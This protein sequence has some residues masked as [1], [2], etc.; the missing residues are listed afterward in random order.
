MIFWIITLLSLAAATSGAI[1]WN[2]WLFP[3]YLLGS[4]VILAV[5]AIAFVVIA[6]SCIDRSKPQ[7]GDS[8][9]YRGLANHYIRF[10]KTLARLQIRTQGLEKL[11]KDGRF[12]LVCNHLHELDPAMLLYCFPKSQLAFIAKQ[13]I[14]GFFLVGPLL[15]K[16]QC[17]LIN[18]ENDREALKTIL[19]CIQIVKEDK[20][21]MGVFPEGYCSVSGKLYHFRS[22]VFKIAQKTGV[23]VVVCTIRGTKEV[24]PR[25]LKLR[26]AAVDVH[27]VDVISAEQVKALSTVDLAELAYET[28]IA[29]LGEALRTDEKAVHPDLQKQQL[30][31][32]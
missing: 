17:Q 3:L 28:M 11:P 4:F 23:P 5:L 18:R 13:E 8:K 21:S 14:D 31:Q 29:D 10:L 22:G 26:R 27:L 19:K 16:L 24:L 7:D 2:P 25:L 9:F 20:A 1:F 6:C 12:L 30:E 32:S 15:H